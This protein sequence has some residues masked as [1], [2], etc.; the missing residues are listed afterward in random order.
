LDSSVDGMGRG[1]GNLNTELI[2]N[3]LNINKQADYKIEALLEI[4]D[5][6]IL[7]IK[8]EH[9]WGYTVPYYLA[10]INGCHPN[11]AS[12]LSG[13]QTL[14]IRNIS[15][16]L[17][18]IEV[19]KRS[20]FDK[21]LAAQK[22]LEFQ[23]NE[24]DDSETIAALRTKIEHN[25][26]LILGPGSSVNKYL[27]EIKATINAENCVV[28]SVGFVP[29]KIET[30][31]V[32]LSNLRRYFTTFNPDGKPIKLIHTSNISVDCDSKLVVNF[33][34]FLDENDVIKDNSAIMLFN[35]LQKLN[36]N[37]VFV[38]GLDGFTSEANNYC[39]DRLEMRNDIDRHNALNDAMSH[40]IASLSATLDIQFITPSIYINGKS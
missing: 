2:A 31:Y 32:F 14:T 25:N 4:V 29:E 36:P 23:Q 27:K 37:T 12:Y 3:Y 38:A 6:F 1:A 9:E 39:S 33:S 24:I 5:E 17:R 40:R 13:K 28:I 35:L 18:S 19:S 22:Y 21:E 34:S 16:I 11:Y 10:A 26:V 15:T 8:A 30:D 20:L 7:K